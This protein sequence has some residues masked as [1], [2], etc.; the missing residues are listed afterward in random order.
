MRSAGQVTRDGAGR[1]KRDPDAKALPRESETSRWKSIWAAP[2]V[3]R[4][5]NF[6][7]GLF[8]LLNPDD[9]LRPRVGAVR[10]V[11]LF[12]CLGVTDQEDAG[13]SV[14]QEDSYRV[15]IGLAEKLAG[16]RSDDV[17]LTTMARRIG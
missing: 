12:P 13:R 15:V 1:G 4:A 10:H 7:S 2:S 3:S 8:V 6:S 9:R 17:R 11:L 16:R 5:R 14:D